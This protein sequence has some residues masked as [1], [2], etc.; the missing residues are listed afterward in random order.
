MDT[1]RHEC[2]P[3]NGFGPG[4]V[5]IRVH[6]WLPG[7]FAG[8]VF[9]VD[10]TRGMTHNPRPCMVKRVCRAMLV[11]LLMGLP[12]EGETNS[13]RADAVVL[14]E[15]IP[16]PL[17]PVNRVLWSANKGAMTAVVRPLGKVYRFLVIPPARTGIRNFG[18]NLK[19]PG[20]LLN[21]LLEGKWAG[22]GDETCRFFYNTLGGVGGLIDVASM[23]KVPRSDADF[24][25]TFAQWGWKPRCFLM[26]PVLGPS[27]DRDA[28]GAMFDA[29]ASPLTYFSPY[30][31]ASYGINW[32]N[33]TEEVE[34]YARFSETEKDA[35]AEVQFLSGFT[36]R[37]DAVDFD[38]KGDTDASSLET[39][40]AVS[41]SLQDPEFPGR[42]RTRSVKIPATGKRLKFTAWVQPRKAPA[43]Y[44]VPGLGA[45]RLG[46]TVLELAEL[47][48]GAGYTVVSVS[49][50]Y[51]HEF[52]EHASTAAMPAYTPVDATDLRVALTEIDRRLDSQYPGRLGARA[53]MGYSMGAFQALYIAANETGTAG[54]L[55][56]FD[57]YVGINTPVRLLQGISTLDGFYQ[58]PLVWPAAE[59]TRRIE[60]TF[61]K[62]AAISQ[63]TY[64]VTNALP[65]NAVESKFLVGLAF[66][67]VLRDVIFSS[68]QR[69]NR[70]VLKEPI[71]K[72]RR[73]ALYREIQ[74]YSYED[75]LEKFAV[76]YYQSRGLDLSAPGTLAQ[77]SDLRS[78]AAGL[79]ANPK[80]RIIT[81]RNDFL[82]PAED[83]AWLQTLLNPEQLT[84][85]ETGGHLGNLSQPATRKAILTALD[86]LGV[87]RE[88]GVP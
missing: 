4:F 29:A 50:P 37:T 67:L 44:I 26:L 17:E 64:P 3:E 88:G 53:L 63:N 11:G 58:A 21:N 39:L 75:Y 46:G 2:R 1:N 77:A 9:D 31:Y 22:A 61:L 6:S 42:G 71:K 16:D 10:E 13:T 57:R 54:P 36:R 62:M 24:G 78:Y 7:R 18:Q 70:G 65:F 5:F 12:V 56:Q 35:Y 20:R 76:P 79:R 14:P 84:L 41:F 82:L 52:M 48:Y 68:Q 60:N 28:T 8:R 86:G 51:N 25:L 55:L 83:L 19:Y 33:L 49:N 32:N 40:R 47:V 43:V 80:I 45:H 38:V 69:D 81:N 27:S 30:S 23:A 85:F 34:R 87:R 59:R 72:W 73:D 66:R 74:R 15:S